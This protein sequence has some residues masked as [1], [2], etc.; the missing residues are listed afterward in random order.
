M[1]LFDHVLEEM[2]LLSS[3]R[4]GGN[5]FRWKMPYFEGTGGVAK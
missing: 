2:N 5:G 4:F 3:V 1:Y